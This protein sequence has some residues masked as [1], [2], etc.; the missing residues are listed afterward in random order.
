M[1]FDK[2]A[3][4]DIRGLGIPF[5]EMQNMFLFCDRLAHQKSE[6]VKVFQETKIAN[7]SSDMKS[8]ASTFDQ[9]SYLLCIFW[10]FKIIEKAQIL[11]FVIDIYSG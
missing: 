10:T 11:K 1:L 8:I 7:Y 2:H 5:G 9:C 3:I 6:Q 4:L